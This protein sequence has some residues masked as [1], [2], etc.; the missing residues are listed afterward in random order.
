MANNDLAR[1][2]T[3]DFYATKSEV[4]RELRMSLIDNIWSNILKYRAEFNNYLSLKSIDKNQLMICFCNSVNNSISVMDSKFLR[5]MGEYVNMSSNR[6]D[7]THFQDACLIKSLSYV[8]KENAINMSDIHLRLLIQGDLRNSEN[9]NALLVGYL[10][11]LRFIE[12]NNKRKIDIDYLADLYSAFTNNPNLT[13]FYRQI[14][15]LNPNN[16]VLIDRIYS[17]APAYLIEGLMNNYFSFLSSST[18]TGSIKAIITLYFFNYVKPFP[19]NNGEIAL[20]M[21]KAVLSNSIGEFAAFIP[22]EHLLNVNQ[23]TLNKICAEVQKTNDLTYYINYI[24]KMIDPALEEVGNIKANQL[25]DN[26]RKDLYQEDKEEITTQNIITPS[27]IIAPSS[28]Y[29]ETAKPVVQEEEKIVV[30]EEKKVEEP[31]P[32]AP[33]IVER[34]IKEE[35]KAE[36]E[37]IRQP[38][39]ELAFAYIPQA[40]DEKAASRLEEHLLEMDKALNNGEAS[41]YARNCTMHLN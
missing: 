28:T 11:A 35:K 2:F 8:A 27:E 18:L 25:S 16:R 15:D 37:P 21:M 23:E 17:S 32:S 34:V 26:L 20:L 39:S 10:E 13:S 3:E 9:D 38:S 29:V 14:D 5:Y 36:E 6:G 4:S 12:K 33:K 24:M 19:K 1:R 22:L 7:L 30:K 40:L 31:K 41:S